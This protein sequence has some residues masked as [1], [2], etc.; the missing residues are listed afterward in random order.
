VGVQSQVRANA[1]HH[2][3]RAALTDN[4]IDIAH[5]ALVGHV[6]ADGLHLPL[7]PLSESVFE[8][9]PGPDYRWPMR[10]AIG[11]IDPR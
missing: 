5:A 11:E 2:A 8:S 10:V 7:V 3:H 4:S 6:A 9:T 1:L